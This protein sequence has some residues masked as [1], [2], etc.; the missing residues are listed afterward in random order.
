MS[1]ANPTPTRGCDPG[2]RRGPLTEAASSHLQERGLQLRAENAPPSP[3]QD[4]SVYPQKRLE[5]GS[6]WTPGSVCDGDVFPFY[7][8][9]SQAL[10]TPIS[11][12]PPSSGS[13]SCSLPAAVS[14]PRGLERHV[15]VNLWLGD[16]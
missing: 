8:P 6:V 12:D 5:A 9:P 3:P 14:A 11:S 15:K 4:P 2:L 1:G 13:T 10:Q 7:T 16:S